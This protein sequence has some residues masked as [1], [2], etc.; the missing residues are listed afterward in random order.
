[1]PV[2]IKGEETSQFSFIPEGRNASWQTLKASGR[3]AKL[4][5]TALSAPDLTE[6]SVV[7]L[8]RESHSSVP[9]E[10]MQNGSV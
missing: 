10:G 9:L 2:V 5:H 6:G 8:P 7:E 1:M 4:K 3:L